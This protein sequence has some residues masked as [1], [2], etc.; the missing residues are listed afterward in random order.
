MTVTMPEPNRVRFIVEDTGIGIQP[1]DLQAIFEDFR[2]IDQSHTK[3]FGGTGLGLSI[4]KKLLSLLAGDI[5]VESTY[6]EGTRFIVDVT[7]ITPSAP[8]AAGREAVGSS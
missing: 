3:E 5:T 4:T 2:Q 6:G 7:S 1:S 8:A